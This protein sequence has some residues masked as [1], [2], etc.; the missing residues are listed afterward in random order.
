MKKCLMLF[1]TLATVLSLAACKGEKDPKVLYDEA[2]KKTSELASMDVTS[3][4]NMQMT[5][6]ENTT[7]IKMDLDMKMADINT[8][9]MRYL[10]QGTTSLMGQSIDIL[11]YYENGYYYMDSMGQKVKYA[12]DLNSM[13]DQIKQSTE[14]ASVNS[15]YLKEITA[16]KD[17]AN[18]VLTFT[19]DAEKMD[20]YVQDLMGQLGTNMEGVTYTIKEASGEATVNKDGYFTNSKIKMSLE[21]NAQ[22]QTVAMVMDTDSTYNNPGQTVEVT[23]PDLEGY[24]EIDAGALENQ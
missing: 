24:T 19:V 20:A 4:V 5:Q 7:D 8:E 22:D 9:N 11:M 17:G 13:M 21:M 12:M 3:V 18:Q 14:G 10:A 1:L 16:K 2:S 23:A 6:G 15:S